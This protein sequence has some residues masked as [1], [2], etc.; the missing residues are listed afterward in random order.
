[1][2]ETPHIT[3]TQAQLIA[4]IHL[5]IPRSEMQNVMGPGI[6]EIM[7]VL[8]NQNIMPS[9]PLFVHHLQ[10][11]P[12]IFD[13]EI[14]VPISKPVKATGRVQPGELRAAK[15]ARAVYHGPYEKMNSAW[16][17]F[18]AWIAAQGHK[19]AP[20]LW[21]VYLAGP[22]STFDSAKWRTELNRPLLD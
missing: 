12:D 11:D 21:E 10:I 5:T 16:G 6:Q 9:G 7:A 14:C 20:D 3:Q 1:M 8:A 15:V 22:E 4:Y 18:E 17:E 19:S 13:F 2:L